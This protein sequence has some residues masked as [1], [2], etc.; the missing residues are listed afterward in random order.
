[1]KKII[2]VTIMFFITLGLIELW[3]VNIGSMT[4][5]CITVFMAG[6]FIGQRQRK[7]A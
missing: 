5:L 1:L 4:V 2:T 6:L 3:G 7:R